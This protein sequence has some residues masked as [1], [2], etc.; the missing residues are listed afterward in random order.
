MRT[1]FVVIMFVIVS[2]CVEPDSSSQKYSDLPNPH[3]RPRHDV[4]LEP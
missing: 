4:Q 1:L 3:Y 2:G